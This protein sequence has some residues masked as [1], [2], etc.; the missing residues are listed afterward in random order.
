[1]ILKVPLTMTYQSTT[2]SDAEIS[3]FLADTRTA[4]MGTNRVNGS[5]QLSPVWYLHRAEK[6]YSSIYI[7]SAKYRNLKRDPRVTLC[8]D[9]I[10]PDARYVC[11]Y[12]MVEFAGAAS[13]WREEI[14][15]AIAERYHETTEEADRYLHETSGPDSVLLIVSP[16]KILSQNYN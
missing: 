11:I 3:A 4:I 14:E 15:K 6:L 13:S 10:Y 7:N 5:P 16:Q 12:G 8:I 2:L 9:G 1:M